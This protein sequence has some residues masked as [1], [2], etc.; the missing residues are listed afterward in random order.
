M[1]TLVEK[2]AI[3]MP[4]TQRSTADPNEEENTMDQ[5]GLTIL[6]A[7]L[8][9][10]DALDGERNSI[11]NQRSILT[12]YAEDHGFTNIKV[13]VDDGY[14]GTNFNRPGVQEGLRLVE[15]GKV[16]TW[17]VKDMS[18]FGRDYLQVGHYTELVFPSHDVRFIAINDGVDSSRGDNEFTPFRNL[19]NDFYAK[20]TSKKVRAV[21]RNRG[22]SGQHMGK[23]PYGYMEDPMRRG[24]WVVDPEAAKVVKR[25]FDLAMAGLGPC[26]IARVLEADNVLTARSHYASQKGKPL[27]AEPY[28]WKEASVEDILA[29]MEYN[30]C[31]CNFKSYSKSY[32]LK[33]RIPNAEADMYIVQGT[34]EAIVPMEQWKRVQ[35]LRKNKRRNT[36]ADHHGLFSGLLFCADCGSKLTFATCCTDSFRHDHYIC[37]HYRSGHGD[38]TGHYIREDAL[39]EI[40][41]DRIR[42]V[43][44]FVRV[45]VEGFE[46]E[47]LHCSQKE[48]ERAI[49]ENEKRIAQIRKR[50]A[51]IDTLQSRIYEDSVLGNLSRERWQKMSRDYDAEQERLQLE[52]EVLA[53]SMEQQQDDVDAVAQFKRLAAKYLDVPELTPTIVNE[54]IQKI[55]VHAPEKDRGIRTQRI[56]IIFNFADVAMESPLNASAEIV[57]KRQAKTA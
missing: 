29:R 49:R 7:R 45:D 14:T 3:M 53:E 13:L 12:K 42:A 5:Q 4:Y 52:L 34:Q 9:N 17:I 51:D 25:I 10:E 54:Y 30:G 37:S 22:T 40:V 24:Y 41:L 44:E 27:P 39:A 50:L 20:D 2:S 35:E 18:R 21:M 23:P 26:K 28:A 55:I 32:K 6:Y 33:K 8:S 19:F 31:T 46:E 1:M 48:Q 56:Q 11:Q 43:N 16:S 36:K 57:T 15:E 38:C 47:W